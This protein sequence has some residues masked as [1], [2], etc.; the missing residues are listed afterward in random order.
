MKQRAFTL[1]ELLVVIAIIGVLASVVLVNLSGSREKARVAKSLQFGQSINHALG[2]YAMG[3]WSFDYIQENGNATATDVSGYDNHCR[4]IGSPGQV[5]GII[6]NGLSFDGSTDYLD[7]GANPSLEMGTD[8]ITVTVW[9]KT[10][11][12]S[13]DHTGIVTKGAYGG[14]DKGYELSYRSGTLIQNDLHFW[15]GYYDVIEGTNKRIYTSSDDDLGLDDGNWHFI[16]VSADRDGDIVYYVDSDDVG[17]AS[18]AACEGYDASNPARNLHIG[19]WSNAVQSFN[20]IIDEVRI[21]KEAL[22]VSEIQKHY[23]EGLR[24]HKLAEG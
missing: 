20:G 14:V 4:L 16:A 11:S 13:A 3:I 2:A 7:C 9:I 12:F 21:Y 15:I 8:D 24:K 6:R 18:L 17:S 5:E 1:I 10:N 23:V 22:S 19:R